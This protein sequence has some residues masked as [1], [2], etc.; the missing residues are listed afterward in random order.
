M[1]EM[2][3]EKPTRMQKKSQK[4]RTERKKEEVLKGFRNEGNTCY[5]N[6]VLSLLLTLPDLVL[7]CDGCTGRAKELVQLRENPALISS[8][9]NSLEKYHQTDFRKQSNSLVSSSFLTFSL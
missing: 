1:A 6:S 5:L 3:K 7:L 9:V 2:E 8:F 4:K